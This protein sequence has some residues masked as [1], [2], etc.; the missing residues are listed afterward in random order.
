MLLQN[1]AYDAVDTFELSLDDLLNVK[2][3]CASRKEEDHHLASQVLT[4]VSAQEIE[5]FEA[6]HLRDIIDRLVGI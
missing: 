2:V 5:Q 4:V 1:H 3:V 6:R